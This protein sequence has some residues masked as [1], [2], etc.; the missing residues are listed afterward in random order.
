VDERRVLIFPPGR[1]DGEVTRDLLERNGISCSICHSAFAVAEELEQG[2]GALVLTDAALGAADFDRMLAALMRQPPW[3]DLPIVMLCHPAT[4]TSLASSAIG[5]LTNVT[6]L[7]RPASARTLLSAVQTAIRGRLR[8]YETREQLEALRRAEDRLLAADRRKDEFL[9]M[10]AHELRSPLAPIRNASELLSRT[11]EA[12]IQSVA[13][14]L[15]RQT[16]HLSRLVDDLLDVSRITQGRIELQ[17]QPTSLAGIVAIAIES[18]EPLIREKG[19]AVSVD[20]GSSALFTY[21]DSARLVQ[22]V[23]NV[24]TNSVKYTDAGGSIHVELREEPPNAVISVTDNGVG[25]A[26]EL[27]PHVFEL[28]VQGDR[29]LDRAQGGLGIGLSVV[30]QLIEM[31]GGSVGAQSSEDGQGARFELR[32]PI[33]PPPERVEPASQPQVPPSRRILIVDDN[34]DAADSLALLLRMDGHVAEPVYQSTAALEQ[35]ERFDP[36]VILLD[37]GLP[38]MDGYE[39][40]RRLRES[41]IT[42]RIVALTGYGQPQD[43]RRALDAGFDS[44]L[45]KPVEMLALLEEL[46][47]PSRHRRTVSSS[48]RGLAGF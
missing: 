33:A 6:I 14:I 26:A 36:E 31:H 34:A 30:K 18:V 42:A 16:T 10:L 27:L 22:C 46:I 43:I 35:A 19:H 25:I 20:T 44:H 8:Q 5:W 2:A 11:A 48:T 32:L 1:R 40:A 17:R 13:G 39:V 7:D 21:G 37:I 47:S 24:I 45:V 28:F 12:H 4:H 38:E 15:K 29:S 41:G 23:A 3:S 9:A